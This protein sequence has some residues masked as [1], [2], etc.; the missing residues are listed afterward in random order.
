MAHRIIFTNTPKVNYSLSQKY[1]VGSGVG[2]RNR[3]VYRALQNRSSNN[4]QGKPCCINTTTSVATPTPTPTPSI[5][6]IYDPGNNTITFVTVTGGYYTITDTNNITTTITYSGSQTVTIPANLTTAVINIYDTS[7]TIFNCQNNIDLISL[8]LD[9]SLTQLQTLSSS[10]CNLTTLNVS[11][12]IALLIIN[13]SSNTNLTTLTLGTS[14]TQLQ[15]LSCFQCNLTT[16][17]VSSCIALSS[18]FCNL[19]PNLT[20]VT[21]GT[22]LYNLLTL[23]CNRCSISQTQAEAIATSILNTIPTSQINGFINIR[24][25]TSGTITNSGSLAVLTSPPYSWFYL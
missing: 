14:L 9:P 20:T 16:L 3:S 17:N 1:V 21:L 4:A 24:V 15:I 13:C 6:L 11:S 7:I 22:G 18:I 10:N 12:C 2:S 23:D 19:N 8:T 5:Q 25:Q